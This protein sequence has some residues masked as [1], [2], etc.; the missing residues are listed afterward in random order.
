MNDEPHSHKKA[1]VALVAVLL[2]AYVGSYLW[3][4]QGKSLKLGEIRILLTAEGNVFPIQ[5]FLNRLYWPLRKLEQQ[6]T[7]IESEF[8]HEGA[9]LI[10]DSDGYVIKP[11]AHPSTR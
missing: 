1:T 2:L 7:G 6:A 10:M 8:I 9:P 4:L 5:A 11:A 3:I